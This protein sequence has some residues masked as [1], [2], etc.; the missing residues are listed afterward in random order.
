MEDMNRTTQ[1]REWMHSGDAK[2]NNFIGEHLQ[3]KKKKN[4]NG[5]ERVRGG[6]R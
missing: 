3:K 1:V 5:R 4:R 2:I 6:S